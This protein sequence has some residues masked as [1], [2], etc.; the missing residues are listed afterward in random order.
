VKYECTNSK[1]GRHIF[2]SFFQEYI[3]RVKG[4]HETEEYQESMRKPGGMVGAF[5]LR[6][7]A[8][9]PVKALEEGQYRRSDRG[10]G[11]KFEAITKT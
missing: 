9:S 6:G 5:I 1:S 10:I 3:E 8:I 4:Y 2:R 11:T 7:K